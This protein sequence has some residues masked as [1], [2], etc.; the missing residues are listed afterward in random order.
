MSTTS[1]QPTRARLTQVLL[2]CGVA[3]AV[4][5]VVVNDIIAASLYEG[6]DP[7]SQA[8]SELSATSSPAK[9]FLTAITPVWP[10]LMISFGIGVRRAA[11]GCRALRVV[12]YLL[13]A[14]AIVALL[15][16]AFPM[17]SRTDITPDT[18]APVN[19]VGHL[20]MTAVT[21]VFVLS[22]I[23]FSA[24]ALGWR[25]RLYAI[26]SAVTVVVFG[27]L[28]GMQA[29][30]LPAGEPTPWMGVFER[31]TIAP[32]LLWMVVLAVMLMIARSAEPVGAGDTARPP[33]LGA[34]RRDD[35]VDV[36]RRRSRVVVS[37]ERV[38]TRGRPGMAHDRRQP[39]NSIRQDSPSWASTDAGP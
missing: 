38:I 28:T 32:W 30:K 8:I 27:V 5:Y 33:C 9:A 20:V 1:T 16:V 19:D 14:H 24:A 2:A 7:V 31:L 12:G 23:G 26:I 39:P 18:P 29:S 37:P 13:I 21:L 17:T 3:Y 22:Q 10:V 34:D 15:W 11:G 6:Y 4:V 36:R 25:F 35:E